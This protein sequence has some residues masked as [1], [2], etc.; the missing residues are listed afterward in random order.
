MLSGYL[1]I[2]RLQKLIIFC[3]YSFY[4]LF[5]YYFDFKKTILM[6]FMKFCVRAWTLVVHGQWKS[7][8]LSARNIPVAILTA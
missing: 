2:I 8:N 1:S 5:D 6:I 3:N 7:G 4:K